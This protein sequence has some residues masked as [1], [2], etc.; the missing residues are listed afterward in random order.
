M[1]ELDKQ[2]ISDWLA[3]L[4]GQVAAKGT[5]TADGEVLKRC[6]SAHYNAIH[7]EE[8]IKGLRGDLSGFIQFLQTKMGWIVEHD[9]GTKT[10]TA[11]ENKPDCVCPLYREGLLSSPALCE[12]SRGFAEQMFGYIV[13]KDVEAR[14]VESVL[15]KGTRCIYRITY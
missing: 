13:G 7:M 12:C 3:A 11:N 2:V 1:T 5:S 6:A 8:Q 14:V 15:R 9:T 4:V 10:I